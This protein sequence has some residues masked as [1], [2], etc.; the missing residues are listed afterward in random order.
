MEKKWVL[1]PV[2]PVFQREKMGAV[3]G[4]PLSPVFPQRAETTVNEAIDELA[5]GNFRLTAN[6]A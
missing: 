3:P 4:F 5:R 2:F 1:S 6:R